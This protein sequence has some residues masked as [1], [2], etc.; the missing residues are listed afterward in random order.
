MPHIKLTVVYYVL[1][2]V[3]VPD[4]HV[5]PGITSFGIAKAQQLQLSK[6]TAPYTVHSCD[7]IAFLSVRRVSIIVIVGKFNLLLCTYGYDQQQQSGAI[8]TNNH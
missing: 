7:V 3:H 6:M 5:H 8:I 2:H 1:V 4:I